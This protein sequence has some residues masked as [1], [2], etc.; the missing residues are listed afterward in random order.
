MLGNV[1]YL[2][3]HMKKKFKQE[4]VVAEEEER[5]KKEKEEKEEEKYR[6]HLGASIRVSLEST[7]PSLAALGAAQTA[8]PQAS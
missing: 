3:A 6:S 1:V 2:C 5:K 4:E 7:A 8:S